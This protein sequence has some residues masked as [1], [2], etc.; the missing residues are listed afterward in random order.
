MGPLKP[1]DTSGRGGERRR[2]GVFSVLDVQV[3]AGIVHVRER[4]ERRENNK[5]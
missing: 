5:V 4:R 2:G 1:H 3:C